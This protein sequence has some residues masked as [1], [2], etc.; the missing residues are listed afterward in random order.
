MQ[1]VYSAVIAGSITAM[2]AGVILYTDYGFW[3]ERYISDD[4]VVVSTSTEAVEPESPTEMLSRFFDEARVQLK[5]INESKQDLLKGKETY[6][7]TGA[8]Q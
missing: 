3:H 1:H 8:D 5:S 7:N 6:V 2:I 4:L